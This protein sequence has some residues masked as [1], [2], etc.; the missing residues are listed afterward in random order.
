M[1]GTDAPREL[2]DYER[3]P[4]VEIVVAVQFQPLRRFGMPEIVRLAQGLGEGWRIADVPPALGRMVEDPGRPTES[5]TMLNFGFQPP[6]RAVFTSTDDRWL[7]QVQSDR[8][9]VHERKRAERPSFAHV[10]PRLTELRKAV[11]Q[12]VDADVFGE[13]H[14]PELVEVIYMNQIRTSADGAAD[15]LRSVS[16]DGLHRVGGQIDGFNQGFSTRLGGDGKHFEGRL[17]VLA[18]VETGPEGDEALQLQLISR[19]YVRHHGLANV[20]ERSH[21]DI[22]EGFTAITHDAMH[23]HWGRFR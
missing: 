22:V 17:R 14:P 15:V 7:A 6:P 9:A 19:R 20:L 10:A 13:P 3:P 12:A 21:G 18:S 23:E 11:A 4:V 2:P 8:L 16:G 1:V 5:A